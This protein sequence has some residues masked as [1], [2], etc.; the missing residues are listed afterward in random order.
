[1]LSQVELFK[2]FCDTIW[3][4]DPQNVNIY[5]YHDTMVPEECGRWMEYRS[6][7]QE[8][9]EKYVYREDLDI[10]K[11]YMS[12]EALE[13]FF[14]SSLNEI[15]FSVRMQN[16]KSGLQWHEVYLERNNN[17]I[18]IGSRDIKAEQRNATIAKA[19]LP[20]FDYVCRIDVH[21]GSYILYYA[22]DENTIVPQHESEDYEKIVEEFNLQHV[23]PEQASA[24]TENMRISNLIQQLS[25]KDEY[26]LYTEVKTDINPQNSYKC[27]R[28]RYEDEKKETILLTRTDVSEIFRERK[29]RESVEKKYR[30]LLTNMPIAICST[31][32]LLDEEGKPYD[33]RY[34]Y[35]NPAHEE[36]EGVQPG[37]LL[38]KGFY[39]FFKKTDPSWL[40]YYYETAWLG[41][42][43][44]IRKYS[45]EIGKELLVHTFCTGQGRCD[46]VLQDVTQEA[47]L[48]R[49]LHQSRQEM[50][51]VLESTTT[52]VF[53]YNPVTDEIQQNEYTSGENSRMYHIDDL[54][55]IFEQTGRIDA[56]SKSLLKDSFSRIKKGEHSLSVP[57]RC[58]KRNSEEWRWF[59]MSLFD[60]QDENTKERKV[61]GYIQ[62][63]NHDMK[64]QEKLRQ[65]AQTD[66]L[67]GILNVGAGRSKI[68]KILDHSKTEQKAMFMMDVDNFKTVNDTYGHNIGDK[69]LKR[70]AE[71]LRTVFYEDAVIYRIGGDEFSVFLSPLQNAEQKIPELMSKLHREIQK[72]K[73]EFPFF[74]VSVGV[75]VTSMSQSYEQLYIAADKALYQTKKNEKGYYTVLNDS[76]RIN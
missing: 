54:V 23:V 43:H 6:L 24:L 3:E 62:D 15:N 42:P 68:Q 57:L 16:T 65:Q 49:E 60:Y 44:V 38:G 47:F 28:F 53:Q 52:A 20:E 32:V 5:I 4:Y 45:P 22:D 71:I 2:H 29:E 64:K 8:H 27:L 51:R 76:K 34:T 26:I 35:C 61:L 19:V 67:T 50:L 75:Y 13:E 41:I 70:F 58:T 46:C 73:T 25:T 1:M 37:E 63:I 10:W 18:I 14:H 9:M 33:F 36:L 39:E 72:A 69:T 21:T 31:E 7:Y 12:P 66:A 17:H 30:E 56:E 40:N 59:R 48:F 74:S 11:R 55:R